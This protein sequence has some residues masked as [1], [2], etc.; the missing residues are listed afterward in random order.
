MVFYENLSLPCKATHCIFVWLFFMVLLAPSRATEPTTLRGGRI[1]SLIAD[2]H[3]IDLSMGLRVSSKDWKS[4][5][6]NDPW[7]IGRAEFHHQSEKP[8][9]TW[10]GLMLMPQSTIPA[11]YNITA[12]KNG[13]SLTLEANLTPGQDLS[14]EGAFYE[15]FLPLADFAG[16]NIKVVSSEGM[17]TNSYTLPKDFSA[18]TITVSTNTDSMNVQSE[19]GLPEI[20]FTM[21]NPGTIV[22]ED[23]RFHNRKGYIIRIPLHVG[24]L[25]SDEVVKLNLT[26][27]ARPSPLPDLEMALDLK[28]E[29]G[30]FH[31]FGGNY[32]WPLNAP[33]IDYTLRTFKPAVGRVQ[34]SLNKWES[35]NDNA[36]PG[37][38]DF[39]KLKSSDAPES[40]LRAEFQMA[41]RLQKSN[42]ETIAS[43]WELPA[44][45]YRNDTRVLRDGFVFGRINP[46]K[47]DEVVESV[48]SYL[49]YARLRYG[50][51]PAYFSF[52]EPDIGV[53]V[54]MTPEMHTRVMEAVVTALKE[55]GLKT[56]VL[57]GGVANLYN[58]LDYVETVLENPTLRD[59]AGGIAV[60]SWIGA[61]PDVLRAW[62]R[63]AEK[64]NL[65]LLVTEVGV[66]P[67]AYRHPKW[68]GEYAY[69]MREARL[70]L[71]FLR[72]ARPSAMYQWQY[73]SDYS[74]M[75][76]D[77][78]ASGET[79]LI[80]TERYHFFRH[81]QT[82]T[83]LRSQ[84]LALI[85]SD[86]ENVLTAA[87]IGSKAATEK[88]LAI[89]IV[90]TDGE[91][92]V[93]LSGLGHIK[94]AGKMHLTTQGPEI[95]RID[96]EP[97]QDGTIQSNFL[98][99]A[100][101]RLSFQYLNDMTC[102]IEP[103]FYV[104]PIFQNRKNPT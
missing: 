4:S 74:I 85:S 2:G 34:M 63:L 28:K 43:V 97:P 100:W 77:K 33:E 66:D 8:E 52:N 22:V 14:A 96:L 35:Q 71:Q 39:E 9:W 44:W 12:V 38:T 50:F 20:I 72:Y 15:I 31:S 87:F 23:A 89:H 91:R 70:Y 48:V 55:K 99:D 88:S 13:S 75:K 46:D 26:I 78:T 25:K 7:H 83:P 90:N 18:K 92:T 37:E 30:D 95:S 42:I 51:E 79:K 32:C 21:Q 41:A 53:R 65:P 36:D 49:L 59:Q 3:R 62:G 45:M 11:T 24:D 61:R 60:H 67:Y 101:L 16:G 68:Y 56:K 94:T 47:I 98:P 57:I 76:K 82:L 17:E 58:T 84:Y 73:T 19:K 102:T 81:L 64:H 104:F 40:P 103:T 29:M 93:H 69:A 10:S 80:P 1:D 27:S 6:S 54:T 5:T 86:D